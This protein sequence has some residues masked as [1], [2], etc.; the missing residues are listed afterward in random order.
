MLQSV[1]SDFAYVGT[2]SKRDHMIE[3]LGPI[4]SALESRIRA[5]K[6]VTNRRKQMKMESRRRAEAV[7]LAV[8]RNDEARRKRREQ[9]ISEHQRQDAEDSLDISS[10]GAGDDDVETTWPPRKVPNLQS[11]AAHRGAS[12]RTSHGAEFFFP[13]SHDSVSEE[14]TP[15]QPKYLLT[16]FSNS[17][18]AP[19]L[20]PT[21][22]PL[23]MDKRVH[24]LD[25]NNKE[26]TQRTILQVT[27]DVKS[28]SESNQVGTFKRP[29]FVVFNDDIRGEIGEVPAVDTSAIKKSEPNSHVLGKSDQIA[30]KSRND[31]I[32]PDKTG[33]AI[34]TNSDV[35]KAARKTKQYG[36]SKR[37][38]E[39]ILRPKKSD[40]KPPKVVVK[41]KPIHLFNRKDDSYLSAGTT[42]K[43]S[44]KPPQEVEKKGS[45]EVQGSATKRKIEEQK[46][47]DRKAVVSNRPQIEVTTPGARASAETNKQRACGGPS[48]STPKSMGHK[49]S[50]TDNRASKTGVLSGTTN[51]KNEHDRSKKSKDKSESAKLAD[52]K[53]SRS[54]EKR[55]VCSAGHHIERGNVELHNSPKEGYETTHTKTSARLALVEVSRVASRSNS[56]G[57]TRSESSGKL[58][59]KSVTSD[60]SRK[61]TS[62]AKSGSVPSNKRKLQEGSVSQI[63]GFSSG[64]GAIK[65]RRRKKNGPSRRSTISMAD[66]AYSFAF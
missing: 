65:S 30:M 46:S 25:D 35:V 56:L 43:L 32:V 17:R 31:P 23:S 42:G 51:S 20:T 26:E 28:Q 1:V 57:G 49:R 64:E 55:Q 4:K 8:K 10:D 44:S 6:E 7:A 38:L 19:R 37:G 59:S 24:W 45:L 11:K 9:M 2:I 62:S 63:S 3:A 54:A 36:T 5:A 34:I 53:E 33:D 58:V 41:K 21:D 14:E 18:K 12:T 60:P 40:T 16:S 39:A 13:Q 50:S 66:D 61:P 47:R 15:A 29:P 27:N 52:K 22:L 48:L